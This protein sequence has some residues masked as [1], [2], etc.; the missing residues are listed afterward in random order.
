M[1]RPSLKRERPS[2]YHRGGKG[3]FGPRPSGSNKPPPYNRVFVNN[4]A[5]EEKWQSL[6]DSFRNK[7]K[8]L[9]EVM[10]NKFLHPRIFLNQVLV[11]RDE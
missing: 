3:G 2:P 10:P 6:K 1:D 8:W 4:I 11:V 5:Y 7:G 9:S